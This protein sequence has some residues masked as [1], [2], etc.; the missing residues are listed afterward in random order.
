MPI[1]AGNIRP[2]HEIG[3]LVR[4]G[5]RNPDGA[6]GRGDKRDQRRVGD[7]LGDGG[8][9]IGHLRFPLAWLFSLIFAGNLQPTA[10]RR[11]RHRAAN[12]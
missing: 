7:A 11:D 3:C 8:G 10:P 4:V 5:G 6:V 12:Q 2:G 9:V 1:G